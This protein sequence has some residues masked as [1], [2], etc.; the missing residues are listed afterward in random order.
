MLSNSYFLVFLLLLTQQIRNQICAEN[1]TNGPAGSAQEEGD[2]PV[3]NKQVHFFESI[4]E[5]KSDDR[6]GAGA[7]TPKQK[8]GHMRVDKQGEVTY[9]RVTSNAITSAIQLGI[10][11]SIQSLVKKEKQDVLVSDYKVIEKV[12]FPSRGSQTTLPHDYKNFHFETYYPNVFRYL[13]ELY[14]INSSE[15]LE[16]ICYKPLKELGNPGKSGS[17]FYVSKDDKYIIK[18]VQKNEAEFLRTLLQGYV[19]NIHQNPK[20]FLSKF[21]GLFSYKSSGKTIRLLVMNNLLPTSIV[22]HHKFDLKGSSLNRF[23]SETEKLKDEPTLKDLDF[24]EEFEKGII[25]DA[26]V[27]DNLIGIIERDVRVLESHRITDYSLLL[28]VHNIDRKIAECC[29]DSGKHQCATSDCEEQGRKLYSAAS[30]KESWKSFQLDFNTSK[31]PYREGG[32]PA[33]NADGHRL[34]IFIG[35]ID[36]LQKYGWIKWT[37]HKLKSISHESKSIS[38]VDPKE[39]A[40][41]FKKHM[42]EKVFRKAPECEKEKD[43]IICR[44]KAETGTLNHVQDKKDQGVPVKIKENAKTVQIEEKVKTVKEPVKEPVKID[45][46]APECEKEEEKENIICRNKAETNGPLNSV[47]DRKDQGVPV[48]IKEKVKPVKEPVK[49]DEKAPGCEIEKKEDHIICRNEDETYGTLKY[50]QD[51]KD[52]EAIIISKLDVAISK[53]KQLV[54]TT[55][56]N[57]FIEKIAKKE[58]F[59]RIKLVVI[60]G[61]ENEAETNFYK[62]A[63]FKYVG[64]SILMKLELNKR[65]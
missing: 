2:R 38:V 47:Q 14:E 21:F 63:G 57:Y 4:D 29:K 9:K 20:T 64:D 8:L 53:R 46:K 40:K 30:L 22:M 52:R 26:H 58:G 54:G 17:L 10:E 44:N 35:I 42:R 27:Y 15:F 7:A 49:I 1:G 65:N 59:K 48:K 5:E 56:L 18:T 3:T 62:K 24:D 43:N 50:V 55:L 16:S 32:V 11:Y 33:K 60:R 45:E 37:E 61:K 39:Y 34:L 41:R 36:I 25:L 51:R 19:L 23:A 28:G 13:R 6:D 31:G 12:P